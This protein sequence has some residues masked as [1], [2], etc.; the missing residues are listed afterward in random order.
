[1]KILVLLLFVTTVSLAQSDDLYGDKIKPK[2]SKVGNIACDS[3]IINKYDKM[4]GKYSI[5][6]RDPIV[7]GQG[8]ANSLVV[9]LG[10]MDARNA[11]MFAITSIDRVCVE[12]YAQI[13]F[14]FKGDY[15]RE[16][17]SFLSYNCR[18]E[19]GFMMGG[20]WGKSDVL[21]DLVAY[22]IVAIRVYTATGHI[23][24]DI[25]PEQAL[26]I[27]KALTCLRSK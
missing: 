25:E 6:L 19:F 26:I 2:P 8:K 15:R 23:D 11:V 12:Q 9:T 3:L 14:L 7:I 21:T 13:I 4:T 22:D 16:T 5:E 18:G 10:K 27:R 1:M 17:N 20:G 24:H